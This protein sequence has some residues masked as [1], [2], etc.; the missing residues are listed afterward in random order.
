M[1][2]GEAGGRVFYP[3]AR[4]ILQI[5]F[6]S[7]DGSADGP[8]HLIPILPKK[9]TVHINSYR[10]AD[11]FEM[12]FDA[13]DLPV[14]PNRVLAGFTEIYLF[15]ML[16]GMQKSRA[17]VSRQFTTEEE[18]A[19]GRWAGALAATEDERKAAVLRFKGEGTPLIA[20]LFDEHDLE[21]SGD[22][23]WVTITGQDYTS[24]LLAKQWPPTPA[25]NAQRVPSGQKLHFILKSLLAKADPGKRLSLRVDRHIDKT[26][27]PVVGKKE[28]S[29]NGRGIPVKADT[30]YWEVM[31]KLAVRHG[32]ILFV[33]GL[34]VVLSTPRNITDLATA[35]IRTLAWGGNIERINLKRKLMRQKSAR[36]VIQAYDDRTRKTIT[37]E[38]PPHGKKSGEKL[39]LKDKGKK[40]TT[41][42]EK[43]GGAAKKAPV[44]AA[45]KTVQGDDEY[46]IVPVFGI[47]DE[48]ILRRAAEGLYHLN[49]HSEREITVLTHDLMDLGDPSRDPPV[50][51]QSL[52]RL[53]SGDAVSIEWQLD[54]ALLMNQTPEARFS[55]MVARGYNPEVA[56]VLAEQYTH[57]VGELRPLRVHEASY[58]FDVDEGLSIEIQLN[59]FVEVDGVTDRNAKRSAKAKRKQRGLKDE[60]GKPIAG[61]LGNKRAA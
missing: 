9:A 37:V 12:T 19:G 20:G 39:Q 47:T 11:S 4:A 15:E 8:E 51:P 23:K 56:Q 58:D 31:Y 13:A 27:I 52:L 59:D 16:P 17:V 30:S 32:Y 1:Q 3:A 50:P 42:T 44:K 41:H 25:G 43:R 45:A 34:E 48:E 40:Q 46:T 35:D 54:R 24:F 28:T 18:A 2:S 21:M 22:G 60:E 29:P 49:G 10:Q 36:I 38:Y 14:D 55:H 53:R 33:E 26:K 57:L 6:R 5:V 61:P 7:P